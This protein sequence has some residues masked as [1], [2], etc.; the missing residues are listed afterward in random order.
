MDEVW[1]FTVRPNDGIEFGELQ[2]SPSVTITEPVTFIFSDG[3]ES[4]DFSAWTGTDPTPEV[5]DTVKHC[6]TY[7]MRVD[8]GNEYASRLLLHKQRFTLGSMHSSQRSAQVIPMCFES[9]T[10]VEV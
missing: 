9:K 4:G 1:Y 8:A 3:F 10:S 2:T 7:S 6:G 5:Q